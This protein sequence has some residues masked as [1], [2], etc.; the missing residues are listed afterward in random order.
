MLGNALGDLE[1]MQ[2]GKAKLAFQANR[3]ALPIEENSAVELSGFLLWGQIE[4]GGITDRLVKG[5]LGE[6]S[7]AVIAGPTGSGKTFLALDM[8]IHLANG[9]PW[10]GRKVERVGV[11]Y[12]G[13][14]GQAGLKKRV[15]AWQRHHGVDET[16]EVPFILYPRVVDLVS[17]GTGVNHIIRA[18]TALSERLPVKIGLI[19]IDTLAR[20]FG[21]GDENTARDMGAFVSRCGMLQDR[22]KATVLTV[23]HFG[24]NETLGMRGSVAL[25]AA[26]DSVIEVTGLSGTRTAKVEKQKDGEAGNEFCF[27]LQPVDLDADEEGE[28]VTSCVVAPSDAKPAQRKATMPASQRVAMDALREAIG[29]GGTVAPTDNHIPSSAIVVDV[30]LWRKFAYDRSIS[31]GAIDAKEAAFRRASKALQAIGAIGCWQDRV[32]I[33]QPQ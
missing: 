25:K 13:A 9:W 2:R 22:C 14:E 32:W 18:V 3:Q 24:K 15:K 20:C 10:F 5:L 23:H 28:A 26:A 4:A 31:D 11:L 33:I 19:V 7:F 27:E 6:Q 21:A 30:K 12:V 29:A 1:A 17:D 8:A 16:A